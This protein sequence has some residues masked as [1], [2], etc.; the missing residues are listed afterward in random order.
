MG[1]VQILGW[2]GFAAF[3]LASAAGLTLGRRPERLGALICIA[4]AVASIGLQALS[5]EKLPYI[6][7]LV[8][9]LSTAVAFA[10]LALKHPQKLWPGAAAVAQT[11]L[12]AFSATRAIGFP[13]SEDEYVAAINLASLGVAIALCGGVIASRLPQPVEEFA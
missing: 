13:L 9:D 11:L 4:G 3:V 10:W 8:I 2:L 6:A 1:L 12:V 7:A 5:P